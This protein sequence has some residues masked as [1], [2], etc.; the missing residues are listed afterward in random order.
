MT[1][2][3]TRSGRTCGEPLSL[4]VL[5]AAPGRIRKSKMGPRRTIVLV[6]VHV[7][8]AVH[9]AQWLLSGLGDGRRSTLSPIEP[10]AAMY[11]L[12][13][14]RVN[15][16][17]VF[18]VLAIVATVVFGR[19]FCGWGCHMVAMQDAC[20]W[21]MR[22]LGVK[23]KPFRSRLLTWTPLA[24]GI[25]M[26]VWPTVRREVVAPLFEGSR[27]P[28]WLGE[29]AAFPGFTNGFVVEDFWDAFPPLYITFP[30]LLVCGMATVYF[31]G[32]KGFCRYGCPYGGFMRP[33]DRFSPGKV[34]VSDDCNQCGHCTATCTSNIRVHEQVRDYGKIVSPDCHKC[35]DCVSV[36][37]KNALSYRLALPSILTRPRDDAARRRIKATRSKQH[38]Y[39]LSLSED[40]LVAIVFLLLVMCFRQMA[41]MIPLL[42]AVALA[43]IGAFSAWKLWRLALTPNVRLQ[44]LQ[45]RIK[46][47]VTMPGVV[48]IALAVPYLALA[49]WSGMV[50]W[51]LWRASMLDSRITTPME[52]VFAPG[53]TPGAA[54]LS[55]ARAAL[56]HF[57]KAERPADGGF[58]W[59]L[60]SDQR[61]RAAWLAAV[62]GN[63]PDAQ[64]HLELAMRLSTPTIDLARSYGQV[65]ALQGQPMDEITGAFASLAQ[66]HPAEGSLQLAWAEAAVASGLMEQAAAA[67][68]ALAQ[69]ASADLPTVIGGT[70]LLLILGHPRDA[71]AL[72]A[73]GTAEHSES[74]Q[75]WANRAFL[76]AQLGRPGEAVEPMD[77]AVRLDSTNPVLMRAFA[78]VLFAAGRPDEARTWRSRADEA[79]R[80][81]KPSINPQSR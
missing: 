6:L 11:T 39:D 65:L 27:M 50:R 4:P 74:S 41:N 3:P 42:F 37:P 69:A 15:A 75:A 52:V 1:G 63:L 2:H 44:S 72:A 51:N 79:E 34:V 25:Y 24:L 61:T 43:A 36:C 20:S 30:F 31:L 7:V 58:G 13:L 35:L 48:F 66:R 16:G 54:D 68:Q 17:F 32:N 18:F 81:T 23:P 10:S 5:Q 59:G 78:E 67:G 64:R 53:Y 62:A 57:A 21:I 76:L 71:E 47:R 33:V 60:A 38:A 19:F 77:R 46:G 8:I 26:F 40:I 28:A 73:R 9:I 49:G 14:G 45:L 29:T 56:A 70:R 55:N 80:A 12:E 22:R